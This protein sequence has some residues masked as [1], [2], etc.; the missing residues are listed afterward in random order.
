MRG[1]RKLACLSIGYSLAVFAAHYILPKESLFIFAAVLPALILPALFLNGNARLRAI[2]LIVSASLGLLSYGLHYK[3]TIYRISE[4]DGKTQKVTAEL[5]AYP[6]EHDYGGKVRVKLLDGRAKG[7]KAAVYDYD[8]ALPDDAA[9]GDI[10][11]AE[12]KLRSAALR[13]GEESDADISLGVYLNATLMGETE[14]TRHDGFSLKYVPQEL[15]RIL[16]AKISELFPDDSRV[17][18]LALMI[19]NK[20]E[21]YEDDSVNTAMSIAGLSHVVAVSGMHVSFLVAFLEL[22]LGKSRRTSILCLG[23]VWLFVLMSGSSP[24]AIRAGFMLSV[25]L[26]APIVNRE[27]DRLTSLTF[28]LCVILAVN[29]FA[30]G[31]VSLQLSFAAI[32]GIYAFG[33]KLFDYVSEHTPEMRRAKRLKLY[34][35]GA[36]SN[37]VAV[38]AFTFP[39]MAARFGTVSLMSPVTNILCLWAVSLIFIGGY[40]VCFIGILSNAVAAFSAAVLSYLVRYIIWIVRLI[41]KIPFAQIYTDNLYALLWALLTYGLFAV[42]GVMRKKDNKQSLA[43][44][45]ILSVAALVS[46]FAWTRASVYRD[47]GTA[48]ILDVGNGQCIVLTEKE[49]AAVIDCGSAGTTLNAGTAASKLLKSHG[50]NSVDCLVLTHLHSDHA[51]GAVRLMDTMDVKKLV[52]P[53]DAGANAD[54]G[55]LDEILDAA[56]DNGVEVLYLERDTLISA[57][58]I[59]LDIKS[60]YSEGDKN[61]RGLMLTASVGGK[62][63]LITGDVSESTERKLARDRDLSDTDVLIVGHHGSKYATSYELLNEAKPETAIISVGFNSYGHPSDEVLHKLDYFGIE[64][65]RTDISGKITITGD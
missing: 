44:P 19:G 8:G 40:A 62:N 7:L 33:K 34:V 27:N 43:L 41:A 49:H 18:M 26:F 53:K 12:L 5:T 42:Y 14:L 24:S 3:N 15:A 50:R 4:L 6:E 52:L 57:G 61:E 11:I 36:F 32:A 35:I 16:Q 60:P 13:Y 20:D 25:A 46:V 29:P 22:I 39:V 17:F 2:L 48:N 37:S 21:Y 63:I 28:A 38:T 56:S 45:T 9:P 58:N 51:R 65:Y 31:S 47:T 59:A 1:V 54:D 30:A 64:T 23:F 55:I 10:L